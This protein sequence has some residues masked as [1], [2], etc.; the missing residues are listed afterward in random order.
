MP[1]LLKANAIRL[2]RLDDDPVYG[3]YARLKPPSG[4][5]C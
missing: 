5:C 4:D 3:R 2:L 1:L